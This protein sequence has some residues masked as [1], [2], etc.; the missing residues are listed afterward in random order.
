MTV[1]TNTNSISYV[2]NGSTVHF[3][4]DFLILDAGHLKV[5]FGDVLQTSGYVVSGVLSQTGGTVAFAAA[6]GAGVKI[7]LTRSVPFLQLTDYQPYDAFPADSHERAL[8]LL[9]MMA[10]QLKDASDRSMQYPVGGNKWDA[11]GN[12]IINV[13]DGLSDTSAPNI[14]QVKSLIISLAG[15]DSAAELRGELAASSGTDL[16]GYA[17]GMSLTD[18]IG[19]EPAVVTPY[20]TV[21]ATPRDGFQAAVNAGNVRVPSGANIAISGDIS[22]PANRLIVVDFGAVITSNGRF[23]A[24]GV[25]NVHWVINGSVLGVGTTVAPAKSGWPNTAQ[26]TQLGD[27][28][29]FIE[30]GGVTFAGND[31]DNYSVRI[32]PTGVVAGDWV[33]TPNFTD[34]VRQVNRKG[35]AAWNCSNVH[36]ESDGEIYGFEGEAVYWFSRSAAGKNVYMRIGNLHDCRFNGVNVNALLDVYNVKIEKCVTKNTYQGI[37]SSAGDVLNCRDYSSVKHSIYAGQGHGSDKRKISGNLSFDC[38]D[39]PFAVIYDKTYEALGRVKDVVFT[40]NHA[41]N[42]AT[43]FLAIADIENIQAHGNTCSGLKAGR[44]LQ[45]TGCQGG[46][47][48]GNTNFNPV[49]GTEH[50]YEADCY[51]LFKVNNKKVS[52]GGSYNSLMKANDDFTGGLNSV[53]TTHG[54][55]ENFHNLRVTNPNT[56]TGPEYRF[57]YDQTLPFVAATIGSNLAGYDANGA[58]A[59]LCFNNLKINTG[60]TLA[61]SWIMRS[62]GHLEPFL[63]AFSNIGSPAKR[64]N[65]IY[66]ATGA[67][68]TSDEREKTKLDI[69]GA[70][71]DAALE[72]KKNMWKFQFKS[73][74][75][76]KGGNGRYHFGV[77]AQTVG[78]ILAK[79]GLNP[80]EYAFFCHD[81]WED[82]Q[83]EVVAV[84]DDGVAKPTGEMRTIVEA[85]DRYGIRYDELMCFIMSAI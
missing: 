85:G 52:L 1:Q 61:T 65:V 84:G 15:P 60:D 22:I 64:A 10:Q 38:L 81:E 82:E 43:G 70:E 9:T 30:F 31:G 34:Q 36:F 12:E 79:H 57:S 74:N 71:R 35:I 78:E 80:A 8:D 32:G 75:E 3:D 17:G 21:A 45:V 33:G 69:L 20:I 13:G 18:L 24:Y 16:I 46:A 63:D 26:G 14:G 49:A 54:N 55:R 39:V 37:E 66:A 77:G 4:Y 27:E 28:R 7:T 83:I 25:N 58:R 29:G 48:T 40:D 41:V 72:I 62:T 2:G 42:P 19:T 51:S 44:F 11:K 53:I 50:Y 56:G 67:I 68:N 5:Y 47:L 76:E 23:T 6:P 73:A 59:D